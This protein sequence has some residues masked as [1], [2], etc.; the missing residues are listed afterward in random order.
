MSPVR[1]Y[2]NDSYYDLKLIHVD[3][4]KVKQA[5]ISSY[6]VLSIGTGY[7]K[8]SECMIQY[9]YMYIWP[10]FICFLAYRQASKQLL[11]SDSLPSKFSFIINTHSQLSCQ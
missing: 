3:Y 4:I 5:H 8:R 9:M 2:E 1:P 7:L 11:E 6:T 10:T